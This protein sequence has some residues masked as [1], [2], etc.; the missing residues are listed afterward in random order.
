MNKHYKKNAKKMKTGKWFEQTAIKC[1]A[2]H[3]CKIHLC[4]IHLCKIQLSNF[5]LCSKLPLLVPL[6]G[7][8]CR[9]KILQNVFSKFWIQ[10][11]SNLI[12]FSPKIKVFSNYNIYFQNIYPVLVALSER[13][14]RM[15]TKQNIKRGERGWWT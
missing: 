3:L 6:K 11:F 14:C 15:K 1:N 8:C 13:Y 4:K 2:I 5:C 7:H 9:M 12:F 10:F